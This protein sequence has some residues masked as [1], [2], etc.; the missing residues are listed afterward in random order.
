MTLSTLCSTLI[1]SIGCRSKKCQA[2]AKSSDPAKS[3]SS[4]RSRKRRNATRGPRWRTTS[5]S[6]SP[7]PT[8]EVAAK[9]QRTTWVRKLQF[10]QHLQCSFQFPV[11]SFTDNTIIKTVSGL[12]FPR[13]ID[14]WTLNYSN[15]P[16]KLKA[17]HEKGFKIC[18]FTNQGGVESG[19]MTVSEVKRKIFMISQRLAVPCQFY[20]AT[21]NDKYRKPRVGMWRALEE[22][23]NDEIKI[24][25]SLSFFV[26]DAGEMRIFIL[27][28]HTPESVLD[29]TTNEK[30]QY[31]CSVSLSYPL[32]FPYVHS[33]TSRGENTEK[34]ERPLVR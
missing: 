27:K 15:V 28:T 16:A 13:N 3:S 10:H 11:T 12:V 2:R 29:D 24:D 17:L 8:V 32:L 23:F 14:D 21:R 1:T 5:V 22:H 7:R 25:M 26:G 18:V 19:K 4:K 31:F 6:C 34:K 9:L 20:I 30:I 33:R